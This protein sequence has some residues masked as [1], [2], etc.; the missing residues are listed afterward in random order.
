[1]SKV[2]VSGKK[3]R[4][5]IVTGAIKNKTGWVDYVYTNPAESGLYY[6]TTY[7]KLTRGSDGKRYIVC[8]GKYKEET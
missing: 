6:K 1:M 5:D 4:D 8:C 3:F 7:Y 2:D